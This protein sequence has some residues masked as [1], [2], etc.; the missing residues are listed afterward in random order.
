[1]TDFM[2]Q[3]YRPRFLQTLRH[4][5]EMS[6][7]DAEDMRDHQTLPP[8]SSI[9]II[10]WGSNTCGMGIVIDYAYSSTLCASREAMEYLN[11]FKINI[12]NHL[13]VHTKSMDPHG[14]LAVGFLECVADLSA[15]I[16]LCM[17]PLFDQISVH[18]LQHYDTSLFYD[19][20]MRLLRE[21]PDMSA[22]TLMMK[23]NLGPCLTKANIDFHGI[24]NIVDYQETVAKCTG[25]GTRHAVIVAVYEGYT[26]IH[27]FLVCWHVSQQVSPLS[28]Q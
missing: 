11:S 2:R 4:V 19:H 6:L 16:P 23:M 22:G 17:P 12:N 27:H 3:Y 9:Q 5:E 10:Q 14:Y 7:M 21:E 28:M 13:N 25:P 18:H 24:M 8:R 26:V 15:G 1:M 20:A